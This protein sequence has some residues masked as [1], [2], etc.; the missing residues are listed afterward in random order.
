MSSP[1]RVVVT[2]GTGGIGLAIAEAFA[3]N[4]DRVHV[5]DIYGQALKQVT[6]GNP[7]ISS[8]V[9]DVSDRSSVEAF[10]AEAADILGG[11]DVLIPCSAIDSDR[12]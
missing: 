5:C 4:G 2:A 1:R 9:C 6:E 8:T 3:A 7:A 12:D 10:V 11:I